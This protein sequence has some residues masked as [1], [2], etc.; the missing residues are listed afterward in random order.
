MELRL[1]ILLIVLGTGIVTLLPRVIPL[2]FLSKVELPKW[3]L[4]WLSF[5][6]VTVM[7][8]LLG[9]ELLFEDDNFSPLSNSHELLGII[10]TF[11]VVLL[12]KSLLGAVVAGMITISLLRYFL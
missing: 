2:L 3:F 5:V 11:L 12:T 7:T 8:A 9:Q 4:S 6:P 10:P 1:D